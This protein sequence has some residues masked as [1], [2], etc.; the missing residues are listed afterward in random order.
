MDIGSRIR[1]IRNQQGRT[2]DDIASACGC[3]KS[4]VSKIENGKVVPAVATLSNIANSLGVRVSTLMEDGEDIA[5]AITPNMIERPEA[6][7]TTSKGYSIY[8]LAPHFIDKKMQPV[9]V[10]GK[11]GEV[12]PHSV[13]H[14]G[15]EFIIVLEGAVKI[16]IGN[17]QY[18][19]ATGESVYFRAVN[20]H[21]V[22]P[23]T[24]HA[25]YLDIFVA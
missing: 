20:S 10:Y 1:N 23:T 9:L 2:L 3:S 22:V 16:H 15:E 5:P 12:K 7:V 19:L 24:E 4:L 21:G 18:N 11:K 6:F 14:Q 25:V 17:E 8:A 13:T